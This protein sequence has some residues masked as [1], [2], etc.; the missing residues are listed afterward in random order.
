MH[1]GHHL[2]CVISKECILS[3]RYHIEGSND[4]QLKN[5]MNGYKPT[6]LVNES[7]PNLVLKEGK[8]YN[9]NKKNIC[10]SPPV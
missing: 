3:F 7:Y 2:T 8:I 4:G 10:F 5:K 1:S 9:L 6:T